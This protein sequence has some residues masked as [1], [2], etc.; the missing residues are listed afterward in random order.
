MSLQEKKETLRR[1]S[2]VCC[3]AHPLR[4]YLVPHTRRGGGDG[5]RSAGTKS[6]G[7]GR[8]LSRAEA[9]ITLFWMIK[10]LVGGGGGGLA[11][12]IPVLES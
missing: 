12:L 6:G 3:H 7:G 10:A 9:E 2:T 11:S 5:A 1:H 8:G 4:I